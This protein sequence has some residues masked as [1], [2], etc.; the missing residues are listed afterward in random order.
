MMP[1]L[2]YLLDHARRLGAREAE[3]YLE[4]TGNWACRVYQGQIDDLQASAGNGLGARVLVGDSLGIAYTSDMRREGCVEAV[5]RAI[6]NARVSAPDS[7]REFFAPG[8]DTV[9]HDLPIWDQGLE[10]VPAEERIAL[11]FKMEE[12]AR[13]RDPLVQKV[14]GTGVNMRSREITVVNTKGVNASHKS[15]MTGAF[16]SVLAVSNGAMHGGH[17]SGI[18]RTWGELD[19]DKIVAEAVH[20]AVSLVGGHPVE[21]CDA[22]VIFDRGIASQIWGMLGRT[23][24]GEEA[25]KGRSIFAGKTGQKVASPLV[26]LVDDPLRAD[27]PGASPFD[28]EGV[29]KKTFPII[30]DG[31]L[32]GFMYDMYGAKKAGLVSTGHAQRSFRSAVSASPSNLYMKPGTMTV[33]EIVASTKNGFLVMEVKGLGVGGFNVVSGDLSAG[34]SGLFI[35]DGRYQGPVREVTIAGNLKTMLLE[36]DAV[37]SDFKWSG[38]G[39]PSFRVR[40]MA[41]SGR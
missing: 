4:A 35:R 18:S 11:A 33:D 10:R 22:E 2:S 17:G 25:Q 3:I 38:T 34:A 1:D 6:A 15:N 23:L 27:G 41:V 30:E 24:T 12:M 40:K 16:A 36:V 14:L 19:P 9:Y 20:H 21:S 37:G 29:P 26:S 8:S 32:R 5:D 31:I 13:G 7:F 39:A 28:A